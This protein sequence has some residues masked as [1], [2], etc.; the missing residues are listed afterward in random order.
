MVDRGIHVISAVDTL[1][2]YDGSDAHGVCRVERCEPGEGND[3][4][5]SC[6]ITNLAS[7]I[8]KWSTLYE[9]IIK[10]MIE[11]TYN[12]SHVEK[13]DQATNYWWGMKSGVADIELSDGLPMYTKKLVGLLRQDIIDGRFDPFGGELRSQDG[14]IKGAEDAPLRSK[15][16]IMMD[17]LNENI[18]GEIPKIDALTDEAKTKVKYIGVEKA[19][20]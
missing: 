3:L 19:K 20:K 18:I 15:D 10:T 1:N 16:I 8:Y 9:T 14:L 5:R 17:W 13:K 11:G 7:P 2:N 4:S 12:A 6:R